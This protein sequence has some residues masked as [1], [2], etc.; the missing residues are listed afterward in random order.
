M[1]G[2]RKRLELINR[3]VALYKKEKFLEVDKLIEDYRSKRNGEMTDM[4]LKCHEQLGTYE[5]D[6]HQTKEVRG[7]ELAKLEAKVEA[8]NGV[9][10]AR[11][12]TI[13]ADQNLHE[14]QK[15]EINRLNK[16]IHEL[17]NKQPNVT[18]QQM[19]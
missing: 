3:E 18:V 11:E 13:K 9:V 17:I 14:A 10:K 8:L 7:I 2:I 4:A 16:I 19:K 15:E 12:E 1:F 5:H 6:F